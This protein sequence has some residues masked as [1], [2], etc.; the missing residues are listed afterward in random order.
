[1]SQARRNAVP[2]P[3]AQPPRYGLLVAAAVDTSLEPIWQDGVQWRPELCAASGRYYPDCQASPDT[4]WEQQLG[5]GATG[6]VGSDPFYAYATDQCSPTG[7]PPQ[8]FIDR[9]RRQLEAT[10][11]YQVAAE[12]W[13]GDGGVPSDSD[14]ASP[15]LVE[16]V[17][18]DVGAGSLLSVTLGLAELEGHFA[19]TTQGRRAM[20]HV[21]PRAFTVLAGAGLVNLQGGVWLTPLGSI[22]VG[23]AGY[24]GA[25]IDGDDNAAVTGTEE[26]AYVTGL[27][28]VRQGPLELYPATAE[29]IGEGFTMATNDVQVLAQQLHLLQ[30]DPCGAAA[31]RIDLALLCG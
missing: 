11:S 31:A 9:A 21:S 29:A 17:T 13:D 16:T 19:S 26:W 24:S 2:A 10:R 23:D 3:P 30:W 15:S 28:G 6:L 25:G 7:L 20:V 22:V 8:E 14:Y 27:V 5:D 12:L 18:D 1:M 4:N